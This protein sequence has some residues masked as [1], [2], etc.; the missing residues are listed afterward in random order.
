M[1]QPHARFSAGSERPAPE[2]GVYVDQH[3]RRWF[4]IRRDN[5]MT[6][7]SSGGWFT[8]ATFGTFARWGWKLAANQTY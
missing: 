5:G 7:S 6:C 2:T 8:A 3:G 1:T 4:C